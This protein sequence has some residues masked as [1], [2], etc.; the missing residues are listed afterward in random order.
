MTRRRS[1]MEVGKG[2]DFEDKGACL[3]TSE[4]LRY[5]ALPHR[6]QS[7]PSAAACTTSLLLAA[8]GVL[9]CAR[10][11]KPGVKVEEFILLLSVSC[12]YAGH[13]YVLVQ[14]TN[15]LLKRL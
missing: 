7:L 3:F 9:P 13:N 14:S 5:I 11:L 4:I 2:S 1:L 8:W 6:A 10:A 15:V 12:R